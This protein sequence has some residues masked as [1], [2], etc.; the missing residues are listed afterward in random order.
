MRYPVSKVTMSSQP[1]L[2]RR[3]H[4]ICGTLICALLVVFAVGAK[5]A[6]YF[7][8]PS[9]ENFASVKIWTT[10]ANVA[11]DTT[12]RSQ[13]PESSAAALPLYSRLLLDPAS[14]PV[15]Y[16]QFEPASA[17]D[18]TPPVPLTAVRPPPTH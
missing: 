12:V 18:R 4:Q 6:G 7:P 8:S 17:P 11:V 1:G 10:K 14:D 2:G 16:L 13:Q 3:L 15:R 5:L 9:A